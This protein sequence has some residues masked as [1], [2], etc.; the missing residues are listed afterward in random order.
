MPGRDIHTP[1][2]LHDE[3]NRTL[4]LQGIRQNENGERVGY[5]TMVYSES[6]VTSPHAA[7]QLFGAFRAHLLQRSPS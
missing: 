2:C 3:G 5:N 7:A 1:V 6:E 4:P